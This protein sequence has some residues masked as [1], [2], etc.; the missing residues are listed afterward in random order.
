MAEQ[1]QEKDQHLDEML[2]SLLASYSTAEPRP[3]METRILANVSARQKSRRLGFTWLWAGAGA[4]AAVV[5]VIVTLLNRS[6]ALPKPPVLA[7]PVPAPKIN[8]TPA[9]SSLPPRV[10]SKTPVPRPP[11]QKAALDVR[12]AVFPTPVPVSDQERLMLQYLRATPRDE[13]IAQSHTDP[14]PEITDDD[15]S[16]KSPSRP[17]NQQFSTTTR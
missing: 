8:S 13:V 6:T 9:A 2:D 5:I 15:R 4:A 14:P 10:S 12:Q 7:G 16:F 17:G 1:E 11:E 3:G